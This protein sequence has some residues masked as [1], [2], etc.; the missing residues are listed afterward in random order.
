MNGGL[1]CRDVVDR[2]MD[3]LEGVLSAVER[4]AVEA[5]LGI[6]PRCVAFVESYRETPRFF[7][8]ATAARLPERA[9]RALLERVR[10]ER[11]S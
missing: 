5:H 9:G 2:L 4:A 7:R 6:C 10:R 3:H 1:I 8:E 11:E